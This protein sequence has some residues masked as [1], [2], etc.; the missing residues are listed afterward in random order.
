MPSARITAIA[1]TACLGDLEKAVAH[2]QTENSAIELD[3]F[4]VRQIQEGLIAKETVLESIHRAIALLFDLRGNPDRALA[5]VREALEATADTNIAFIPLF[6]GSPAIMGL[7]R[8][9]NFAPA[10]MPPAKSMETAIA[11][12]AQSLPPETARQAQN[13]SKCVTYWTN[14]GT[15]NLVNLLRFVA[16]EYG[17]LTLSPLNQDY[18]GRFSESNL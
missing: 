7:V 18:S 3:A 14:S 15:D 13:W 9:G 17:G 12:I 16:S 5:L 2:L 8:M 10:K 4:S 6:G 11:S 1:P